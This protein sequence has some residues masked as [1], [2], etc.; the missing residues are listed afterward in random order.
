ML[1]LR[2]EELRHIRLIRDQVRSS[3]VL[4]KSQERARTVLSRRE[5]Q[6]IPAHS[7]HTFT[8]RS[9][10]AARLP[11]ATESGNTHTGAI[12]RVVAKEVL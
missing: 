4:A 10:V 2:S 1:R 7:Q 8:Y 9:Q 6:A 3:L 11:D 5:D 12:G